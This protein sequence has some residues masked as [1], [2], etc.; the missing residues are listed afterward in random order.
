MLREG[1]EKSTIIKNIMKNEGNL[2]GKEVFKVR[3]NTYYKQARE[4]VKACK[5][6]GYEV[7][8]YCEE[9]QKK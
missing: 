9:P 5:D 4:I 8:C 7:E 1:I 2:L 6:S 3:L